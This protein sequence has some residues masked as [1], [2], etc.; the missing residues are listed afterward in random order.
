MSNDTIGRYDAIRGAN[1]DRVG[2][3]IASYRPSTSDGLSVPSPV[4]LILHTVDLLAP[5]VMNGYRSKTTKDSIHAK[6]HSAIVL[7]TIFKI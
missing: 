2:L 1:V 5:G 4:L 7:S 6:L 3:T